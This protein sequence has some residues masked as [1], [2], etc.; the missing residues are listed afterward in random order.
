MQILIRQNFREMQWATIFRD[1]QKHLLQKP[2]ADYL[3]SSMELTGFYLERLHGSP[4]YQF[5]LSAFKLTGRK[6]QKTPLLNI[7]SE[8]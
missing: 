2:K 6:G 7:F 5:Y 8:N 1:A 3:Q 4:I